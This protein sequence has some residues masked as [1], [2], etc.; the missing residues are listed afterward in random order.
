M[1]SIAKK[2]NTTPEE[3]KR[4]NRL[5]DN[6]LSI[7]QILKIPESK[8]I[9]ED[10][11]YEIYEVQKGDSLWKISQKF[12]ITVKDLIEKNELENLV[13]QINQK[14]LVPKTEEDKYVVQKGDT[15]WSIAKANNIEVEELKQINN[16]TSN[17]LKVGQEL[18]IK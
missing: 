2:I 18:I 12:N 13:L 11:E 6:T 8:E 16:L 5:T 7:G 14:L 15:L 9:K 4:I 1:Y 17:L 3:L 10:I